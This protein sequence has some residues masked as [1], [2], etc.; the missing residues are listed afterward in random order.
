MLKVRTSYV[1]Y[2]LLEAQRI[3]EQR[4]GDRLV[5]QAVRAESGRILCG[6]LGEISPVNYTTMGPVTRE[7]QFN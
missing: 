4:T 7:K 2:K 6:L 3:T 5:V 1:G